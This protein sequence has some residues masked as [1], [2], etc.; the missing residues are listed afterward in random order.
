MQKYS[1]LEEQRSSVASH[2]YIRNNQDCT[3]D[4]NRKE[5]LVFLPCGSGICQVL[6]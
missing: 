1:I 3:S 5:E 6:T 2:F 4:L